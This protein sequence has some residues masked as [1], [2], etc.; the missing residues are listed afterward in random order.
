MS[1]AEDQIRQLQKPPSSRWLKEREIDG[2]FF[3]YLEGW[4]A[5]AEANRIFGHANWDRET[6]AS[7]CVASRVIDRQFAVSYLVRVRIVV[8]AGEAQIVRDGCGSAEAFAATPGQ[9]HEKAAKAAETDATKRALSTF[10]PSFG[11]SLYAGLARKPAEQR[12]EP[13]AGEPAGPLDP[14]TGLPVVRDDSDASE[15]DSDDDHETGRIDKSALALGEPKRRRDPDHLRFVAANPCM[16]CGR[17]PSQAHHLRFAQPRALGRKVSD[18][19]TVPLC[20]SCHQ[21]LHLAGDERR[22]WR[23]RGIEPM[24]IAHRLW[25]ASHGRSDAAE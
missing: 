22:W 9:A 16:A 19:F 18:E 2:R 5:I 11:L 25:S 10:G 3:P 4:R 13:E 12:R 1:F 23:E 15:A 8:R 20:A 21:Q 24:P 7:E 6:I 14:E 17:R